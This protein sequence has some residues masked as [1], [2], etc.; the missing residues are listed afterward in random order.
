MGGAGPADDAGM[1]GARPTGDVPVLPG[2]RFRPFG[3][4]SGGT[5]QGAWGRE[6]RSFDLFVAETAAAWRGHINLSQHYL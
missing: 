3:G 4:G 1:D 2:A 5:A 6:A